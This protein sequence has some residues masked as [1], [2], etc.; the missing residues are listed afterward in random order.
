V[1]IV[2][3]KKIYKSLKILLITCFL[4]SIKVTDVADV[5]TVTYFSHMV[6]LLQYYKT[7]TYLYHSGGEV[8][9]L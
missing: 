8:K 3:F 4:V 9:F 6:L 1:C 5:L 7:A 2:N